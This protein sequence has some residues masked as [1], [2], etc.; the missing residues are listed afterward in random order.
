MPRHHVLPDADGSIGRS[1]QRI[2]QQSLK[3]C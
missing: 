1:Q 3:L 2:G